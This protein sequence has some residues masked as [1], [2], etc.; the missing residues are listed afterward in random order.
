MPLPCPRSGKALQGSSRTTAEA[1]HLMPLPCPRSGKALQ[2]SSRTTAEASHLM[3]MLCPR[4]GL[5]GPAAEQSLQY[6]VEYISTT[7]AL[8][9]GGL[10]HHL[11]MGMFMSALML[12]TAAWHAQIPGVAAAAVVGLPHVRLG[13]QVSALLSLEKH[14]EW[15]DSELDSRVEEDACILS[16]ATVK[17]ACTEGGLSYFMVPRSILVQHS[18]LPTNASGKVLKHAVRDI[19]LS[20]LRS[21]DVQSRL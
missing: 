14:V 19:M 11:L 10:V 17:R 13:E 8:H 20:R 2:G 1:S 18:P 15:R 21:S 9:K 7:V 16:A 6:S 12:L 4:S 3:P 5:T